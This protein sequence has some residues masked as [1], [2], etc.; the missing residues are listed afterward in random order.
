[1]VLLLIMFLCSAYDKYAFL[2]GSDGLN[3]CDWGLMV[4]LFCCWFLVFMDWFL[5]Y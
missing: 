4:L 3:Y 1:M 5:G 2:V